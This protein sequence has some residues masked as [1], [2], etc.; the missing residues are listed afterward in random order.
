M[1]FIFITSTSNHH[2]NSI[3]TPL[4]LITNW[5]CHL[6]IPFRQLWIPVT[7]WGLIENRLPMNPE[8][9]HHF[10]YI[11]WLKGKS[12]GNHNFYREFSGRF[13]ADL[14]PNSG[15]YI[16]SHLGGIKKQKWDSFIYRSYRFYKNSIIKYSFFIPIIYIYI[17]TVH[18]RIFR[19]T[20]CFKPWGYSICIG[21]TWD[22]SNPKKSD[23]T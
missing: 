19:N 2:Q 18:D 8:I 11:N 12:E 17:Y 23:A 4:N 16:R 10:P 21:E 1:I 3:T 9:N 15:I 7:T 6:Y 13:P 14:L 20:K 22:G 5:I